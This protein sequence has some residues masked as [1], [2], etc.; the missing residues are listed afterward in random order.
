MLMRGGLTRYV[1]R[2]G[3]RIAVEEL[4]I[5]TPSRRKRTNEPQEQFGLLPLWWAARAAEETQAPG[6]L[7]CVYLMYLARTARGQPFA[8]G[9]VWLEARGASR[10]TKRRIL[11]Q[12]EAAG[13][14]TI[15]WRCRRSPL[16]TLVP[17]ASN[18][19]QT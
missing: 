8:M 17:R 18:M 2:Q 10:K 6:M 13:L 4:D 1:T 16:I 15:N 5:N 12:L 14:V 11:R 7:V 3:K 9:N 19:A